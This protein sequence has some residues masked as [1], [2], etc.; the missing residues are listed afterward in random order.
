MRLASWT[1]LA[2][3]LALIACGSKG[4]GPRPVAVF[5]ARDLA[6]PIMVEELC[7]GLAKPVVV[8]LPPRSVDLRFNLELKG[9][10]ERDV[11]DAI[12]AKDRS[13]Q[14]ELRDDVTILFPSGAEEVASPFSK[15]VP[16]IEAEGGVVGVIQQL[17]KEQGL[18]ESTRVA[19]D[20]AGSRRP[21][22]LS[23][24]N[25][26]VRT[27]LADIVAQAHLACRMEPGRITLSVV[28]E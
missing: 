3:A 19:S 4:S 8:E 20:T 17:L 10:D 13:F 12:V 24:R 11:L 15:V 1:C 23:R 7:G 14:Y 27:L 28:P 18:L 16:S 2:L 9:V 22:K 6:A 25:A 26:T 21:V 5:D